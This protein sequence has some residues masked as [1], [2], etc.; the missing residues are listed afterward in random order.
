M[1]LITG[2]ALRQLAA[3]CIEGYSPDLVGRVEVEV[4]VGDNYKLY[5][6]G[7]KKDTL[8]LTKTTSDL[9]F[10]TR[11]VPETGLTLKPKEFILLETKEVFSLPSYVMGMLTLR[12]Y[13]ARAGLSQTASLLLK[14]NWTGRL[15]LELVNDLASV[16]LTLEKG[17]PIAQIQFY[18]IGEDLEL[19][20]YPETQW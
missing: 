20:D 5:P 12:S 15:I 4:C 8:E 9:L 17:S 3:E 1:R 18:N 16:S 7:L 13:A 6:P 11:P 2:Q 10:I 19:G 14:P